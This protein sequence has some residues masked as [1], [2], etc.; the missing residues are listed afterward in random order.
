MSAL[1]S[2]EA[3]EQCPARRLLQIHIERCI[4]AQ[5]AFMN[6]VAAILR[7][8]VAPD[9]FHVVRSQ[10]IRIFLQVEQDRLTPGIRSLGR[11][12]LAVLKHGIEHEVAPFEGTFRVVDW[13]VIL[14]R[15]GKSREQ[16]GF[17]QFQFLGVFA[18]IK[19]RGSFISVRAMAE[20]YLV[21]V[22]RENLRFGES[23][24]DL[25]GEQRLLHLAIKRTVGR[26]KQIFRELHGERGF[27]LHFSAGFDVAISRAYDAPEV[28]A[29]M[30]VEIFVFDRD[31]SIAENFWIV[32]IG[33]DDA[34]LESK[35]A[36]DSSLSVIEFGDGTGTVTFKL[37]DLGKVRRVD[38]QQTSGRAYGCGE[39]DEQS[40]QDDTYQFQ[41][42]NFYRGQGQSFRIL[43]LTQRG[44]FQR[45]PGSQTH[46][47]EIARRSE[48]L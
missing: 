45:R 40:E 9:F 8:E 13:R 48:R 37:F 29:G 6:L 25:D 26:K 24:L 36:D 15:L 43:M 39:Q 18:E 4:N 22:E 20:E 23:A 17:F 31:Q 2:S 41:S 47:K 38:Q 10:R 19:F 1:V 34:A 5:P 32:V 14:R 35:C 46:K 11:G 28:D 3:V 7:F 16:R 42:A 21:G 12:D 44:S 27:A 33:G 30:P